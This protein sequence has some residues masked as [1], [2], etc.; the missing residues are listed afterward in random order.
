MRVRGLIVM[1]LATLNCSPGDSAICEVTRSAQSP[2]AARRVLDDAT[3]ARVTDIISQARRD[4]NETAEDR[5]QR[6][7]SEVQREYGARSAEILL[8]LALDTNVSNANFV[9]LRRAAALV[10]SAQPNGLQV[11]DQELST[12]ASGLA[13]DSVVASDE[14]LSIA[15]LSEA[16]RE[17][18]TT[19]RVRL[20]G[21]TE[22]L[23]ALRTIRRV[24][25]QRSVPDTS[26][27]ARATGVA[28]FQQS[29]IDLLLAEESHDL[30]WS[31]AKTSQYLRAVGV[32]EGVSADSVE[33]QLDRQRNQRS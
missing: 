32:L 11:L 18:R 15:I 26:S 13:T 24:G 33:H 8:A 3:R 30:D 1:C 5:R 25:G 28:V 20:V 9:G 21:T 12:M 27:L 4:V 16:V 31:R 29:I 22:L 2:S 6:T 23:C 19:Q 7:A 17:S 10:L 14:L